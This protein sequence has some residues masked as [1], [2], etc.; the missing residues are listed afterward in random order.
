MSIKY[1]Y[2][3]IIIS[4]CNGMPVTLLLDD[5]HKN[6]T[7]EQFDDIKDYIKNLIDEKKKPVNNK[8][9]RFE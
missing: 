9:R 7:Y 8:G 5:V 6:I 3:N 2:D 4:K 1:G